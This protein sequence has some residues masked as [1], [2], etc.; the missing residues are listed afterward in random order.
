M[1]LLLWISFGI[2]NADAARE[3]IEPVYLENNQVRIGIDLG[4]GGGIVYFSQK[5]PERN[6]LNHFDKGRFIQQSY[7]GVKDGSK[8]C[9]KEWRWNPVQ[10]GG[11]NDRPARVLEFKKSDG[12]LYV[13]T[14]PKH[15]AT[16]EDVDD[17]TME[18]W[19]DL[20][21]DVAHIHFKFV[22]TGTTS[23]PA[24]HQELPAVFVDYALPN[25]VFYHGAKP[26]TDDALTRK[27]PNFP[28]EGGQPD[29]S[30]AA[31]VDDKDRGIG[32]YFPD[33]KM[34]TCY[35]AKGNGKAGPS[36][37]ACSYF[38]PVETFAITP[39]RRHEY[40]F[41]ITIGDLSKIRRT[42]RAIHEERLKSGSLGLPP[43]PA[44]K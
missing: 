30:W 26:W 10:G 32:A 25:L 44:K 17:A 21:G 18:E 4:A 37:S 34:I 35:R 6:L 9:K 15:W 24:C 20:R 41:F 2:P 1:A 16:G 43:E 29:E 28:N 23:H 27:V 31:Y 14:R 3:P 13:K 33:K 42:F 19:L 5:T 36:G 38:A 40:D 39:G 22:Y 8:W 12:T 11:W 7:Y